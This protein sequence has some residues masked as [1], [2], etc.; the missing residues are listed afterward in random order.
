MAG[1]AFLL[2]T[3]ASL[4]FI[5][6]CDLVQF[7]SLSKQQIEIKQLLFF[8]FEG[9]TFDELPYW[10]GSL[11]QDILLTLLFCIQHSLLK[12]KN[13]SGLIRNPLHRRVIYVL[14]QY[15]VISAIKHFWQPIPEVV[16]WDARW[17]NAWGLFG[18][19]HTFSWYLIYASFLIMQC[20]DFSETSPVLK[21]S[22]GRFLQ[23][24][25]HGSF[26]GFN[27]ILFVRSIMSL[28]RGILAVIWSTY[29]YLAWRPDKRD[30]E[31]QLAVWELKKKDLSRL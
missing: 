26:I 20:P 21:G 16:I 19:V 23:H 6:A 29:M 3:S 10:F 31:Y 7:L 8:K 27:L 5:S 14:S 13:L 28:D 17:I 12:S 24:F 22:L 25:R 18:F 30:L 1:R 9:E 4:S 11:L 15:S 2:V